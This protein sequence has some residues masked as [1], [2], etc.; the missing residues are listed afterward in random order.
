MTRIEHDETECWLR[1]DDGVEFC[2]ARIRRGI[3]E[4]PEE[5]ADEQEKSESCRGASDVFAH[6]N[7]ESIARAS[8]V[9]MERKAMAEREFRSSKAASTSP[10]RRRDS[11][12]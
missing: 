5:S 6:G 7:Y 9:P 11:R 10:A 1:P 8:A 3:D 4:E 12:C 2:A